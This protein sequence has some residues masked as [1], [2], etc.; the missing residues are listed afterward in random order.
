MAGLR[1]SKKGEKSGGGGEVAGPRRL[2]LLGRERERARGW[3]AR[4]AGL[5]EG[6]EKGNGLCCHFCFSF[7][8]M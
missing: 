2:A 7:S 1:G 5:S 4:L 8:K 6:E 3:A